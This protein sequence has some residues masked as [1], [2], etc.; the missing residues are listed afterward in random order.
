MKNNHH[1][2]CGT[3]APGRALG[4][5]TLTVQED[6]G[7]G[8]EEEWIPEWPRAEPEPSTIPPRSSCRRHGIDF[9][10]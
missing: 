9:Q 7:G 4:R 10:P 3:S 2:A 1:S 6:E 5:S 8:Q